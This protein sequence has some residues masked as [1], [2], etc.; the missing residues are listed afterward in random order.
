MIVN[1][2]KQKKRNCYINVE[3]Q[4]VPLYRETKQETVSPIPFCISYNWR[5]VS[6]NDI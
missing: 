2:D 3:E 6:H 5:H 4:K 1:C